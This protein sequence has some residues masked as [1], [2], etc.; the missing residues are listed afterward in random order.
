MESPSAAPLASITRARAV[1]LTTFRRDGSPI[2][3]PVWL[4][5]RNGLLHVTTA[6]SS[7]KVK[8]I[9]RNPRVRVAACTQ[10]GRVTGPVL[11]GEA[12]ILDAA[13]TTEALAAIRR[14]YGLLDLVFTLLNRLQGQGEEI[15]LEIILR[16]HTA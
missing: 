12:R 4:V 13:G 5:V 14:R 10:L 7:G 6:A 8:R 1:M 2:G 3:T 16:D 11:D 9:R 15:A